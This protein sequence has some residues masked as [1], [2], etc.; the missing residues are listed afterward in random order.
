MYTVDCKSYAGLLVKCYNDKSPLMIYGPAGVGKSDIP[1][2]VFAKVAQSQQREFVEWH[3]LSYDGK[4]EAIK[5]PTKYFVFSDQRI[6]QM[7]P[8][9]LRGIPNMTK[10]K[11]LEC[12]PLSWIVYFTTPGASGVIF[13]DEI[14]LAAP[15]VAGQ[16]YQIIRDRSIADRTLAKDVFVFAAGNRL[17]DKAYVHDMPV[18]LRDR[19]NEVEIKADKD[20]WTEWAINTSIN[21][22]LIAFINWKASYLYTLDQQLSQEEKGSSPRSIERASKLIENIDITDQN[23]HMFISVACGSP[24]AT[25]FQAYVKCYSELSWSTIYKKPSIVAD[26]KFDKK[27]AISGGIIEHYLCKNEKEAE[28]YP[29]EKMAEV[30]NQLGVEFAT[31]ILRQMIKSDAKRFDNISKTKAF[32]NM[33]E[34]Y[35]KYIQVG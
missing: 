35:T 25:E 9:D 15:I 13:F 5:N 23:A 20:S 11:M 29:Y 18:P 8:T 21:P 34:F 31:I 16:A 2:Q 27:W 30:V 4:L 14:N 3:K 6:A 10:E 24:F 1:R 26:Y 28:N 17:N 33:A 12:I 19:F 22:H 32:S 7:D